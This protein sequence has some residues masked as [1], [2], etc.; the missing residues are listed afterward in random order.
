MLLWLTPVDQFGQ[1]SRCVL[2]REPEQGLECRHRRIASVEAKDKLVQIAL[3]ILRLNAVMRSVEPGLEVAKD[4]VDRRSNSMRAFGS[5]DNPNAMCV[6][7]QG[8][9]RIPTP[10]ISS[11]R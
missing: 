11:K 1:G 9:I 10:A 2:G 8:R 6:A 7:N 3:E 5:A 4:S